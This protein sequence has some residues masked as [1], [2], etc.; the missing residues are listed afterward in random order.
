LVNNT[1]S[2]N[3]ST[4]GVPIANPSQESNTSLPKVDSTAIIAKDSLN[5]QNT[6][7]I[8]S[9]FP[10]RPSPVEDDTPL[11]IEIDEDLS[12]TIMGQGLGKRK[13]LEKPSILILSEKD[14][15]VAI[16]VC[17]NENGRVES[18]EFNQSK[19]TIENKGLV[20]LAIR[21]SKEFWFEKSDFL[22]QCGFIFY[23]VKGS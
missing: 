20:S 21:K 23:K 14:G 9:N 4:T 2:S 12:I 7:P 15:V 5:A 16:E 17:I 10:T 18:A 6:G 13:I 22:K 11:D 19:S 8:V 3:G 1:T